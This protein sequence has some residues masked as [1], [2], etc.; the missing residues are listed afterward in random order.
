MSIDN[1]T[2]GMER[3][4]KTES[5][6]ERLAFAE[7]QKIYKEARRL[8]EIT[9][10]ESE[11]GFFNA[12]GQGIIGIRESGNGYAVSGV[13]TDLND[14]HRLLALRTKEEE[15]RYPTS[16]EDRE[17]LVAAIR[18]MLEDLGKRVIE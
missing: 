10:R 5:G 18:T 3:E 2:G 14:V 16:A 17:T 1:P 15:R 4:A 13:S 8:A 12:L 11:D 6:L 9:F 7:L